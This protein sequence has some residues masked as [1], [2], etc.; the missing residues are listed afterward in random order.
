MK[1]AVSI[2]NFDLLKSEVK[3]VVAYA[4]KTTGKDCCIGAAGFSFEPEFEDFIDADC[5]MLD[6]ETYEYVAN[7]K[8]CCFLLNRRQSFISVEQ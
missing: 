5:E 1:K 2:E 4:K 8:I 6:A 7:V 3:K